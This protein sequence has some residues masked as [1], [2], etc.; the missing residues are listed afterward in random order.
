MVDISFIATLDS[1]TLSSKMAKK[2]SSNPK[3]ETRTSFTFPSLHQNVVRAVAVAGILTWYCENN[4]N[5]A[6]NNEY[7]THVMGKFRCTNNACSTTGW[8]SKKVTIL[9]RGF[10]GNGYNAEVFNQRC[11]SCN[12]LGTFI[13]DEQSY[14]DR[15]AYRVQKWAGVRM[16]QQ[17]QGSQGGIPHEREF[18][19][20]CKRGLCRQTNSWAL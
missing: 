18:C 17:Y 7:T 4:T 12:Q 2:K 8:G 6:S 20:G 1:L 15:L 10:A 13:L 11:K 14:V 19:E 9:I 16:T 3:G 5:E